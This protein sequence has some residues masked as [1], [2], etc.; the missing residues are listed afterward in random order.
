MP[1]V[2]NFHDQI[3][4]FICSSSSTED[5]LVTNIGWKQTLSTAPTPPTCG[6]PPRYRPDPPGRAE[7]SSLSPL[8][9]PLPSQQPPT[10]PRQD[11]RPVPGA[12]SGY[13]SPSPAGGGRGLTHR[14][15]AARRPPPPREKRRP[16]P[17]VRWR[18]PPRPGAGSAA[19]SSL[20]GKRR[21]WR[22]RARTPRWGMAAAPVRR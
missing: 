5:C 21:R 9:S 16:A 4:L 10:P 1:H 18:P 15:A 14:G 19:P 17:G 13:H 20:G 12:H 8:P 6:A 3:C 22:Q 7:P 11:A 2:S